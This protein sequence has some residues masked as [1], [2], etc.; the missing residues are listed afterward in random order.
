MV[1]GTSQI[2]CSAVE[3]RSRSGRDANAGQ[4]MNMRSIVALLLCMCALSDVHAHIVSEATGITYQ[5]GISYLREPEHP[6]DFTH[7]RY[8]NP[9]APKGGRIRIGD[10]GTWD[11]FNAVSITGR[12]VF[13]VSV[14]HEI[15]SFIYDSL[16]THAIDTPAERYGR[17]AEGI[18]VAEDGSWIAFLL[19]DGA[20]WHDGRPITADDLAFSFDVYKHRG[21]PMLRQTLASFDRIEVLNEREVRYWVNEAVR[22]QPGLPMH[23][24]VMAVLPKHYWETRDITRPTLVPPLGSGPYRIGS[25]RTGGRITYERVPDYWGKDLPV[26]RGRYNFDE[27]VFDYFRDDQVM[28]E[29]IKGDLIDVRQEMLPARWHNGYDIPAVRRGDLKQELVQLLRPAGLH[30]PLFW[31]MASEHLRDI[32]V[33][34]A[35]YLLKDA[36]WANRV[37]NH[38]FWDTPTSFFHDSEFAHRGTPSERELRLLEPFRET[39][40]ERVFTQEFTLNAHHGRGWHRTNVLK[41]LALLEDAGW[42]VRDNRLVHAETGRPFTLRLMAASHALGAAL[43][44]YRQ[45][46]RKVGIDAKIST[47][48]NSG[49]LQRSRVGDFDGNQLSFEPDNTPDLFVA[50]FFSSETVGQPYSPNWANI[51]DP[52]ADALI[53]AIGS[54]DT[55]ED[56]VAAIRA[57]DRVLMWN[58]Y[59]VP[60][61]SRTHHGLVY[62][63]RFGRPDHGRLVRLATIESWWWDDT[64]AAAIERH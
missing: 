21:G 4:R 44:P 50:W 5:H 26:N 33:R 34:E 39:V 31:N 62:W 56:Y 13:G 1:W 61:M 64:R 58:F 6:P 32:R 2:S 52:A 17:L 12:P 24:G 9:D 11:T 20:R 53:A 15:T 55:Y 48:E 8:V 27:I 25:F 40:P 43:I 41:A 29:A 23:I 19:R 22:G 35:L 57:L 37:L 7:F 42:E 47:P 49:W 30:W 36:K 38:G 54:A 18:A 28:F 45:V 51:V 63:N 59:Y 60:T 14:T 46:L 16:L 10:M 3:P